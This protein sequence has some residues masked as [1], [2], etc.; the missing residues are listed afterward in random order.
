MKIQ[1]EYLQFADQ[2]RKVADYILKNSDKI[3]NMKIISSQGNQIHQR[4]RL[5]DSVRRWDVIPLQI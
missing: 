4:P 2:E 3:K 5:P 1:E